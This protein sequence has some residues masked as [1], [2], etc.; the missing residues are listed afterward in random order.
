MIKVRDKLNQIQLLLVLLAGLFFSSYTSEALGQTPLLEVSQ[1]S[2]LSGPVEEFS[3]SQNGLIGEVEQWWLYVGSSPGGR[4]YHNAPHGQEL[5]A[6]VTGLPTDSSSVWGQ[7]WWRL[8]GKWSSGTPVE[9]TAAA[10]GVGT[11]SYTHLTL[12]TIYSV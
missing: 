1:G 2:Q 3:W 10:S 9:F 12:P 7:L 5:A 4:D 6:Q 8:E 11:V